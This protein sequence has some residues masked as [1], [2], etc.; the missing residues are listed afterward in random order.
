MRKYL[1]RWTAPNQGGQEAV[2]YSATGVGARDQIKQL[3]GNMPGFLMVSCQEIP[4]DNLP[5]TTSYSDTSS[6]DGGLDIQDVKDVASVSGLAAAGFLI[7]LGLITLPI[8]IGILFIIAGVLMF[9]SIYQW[10]SKA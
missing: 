7:F 3:Y 6:G 10:G 9:K 8:G 2:V 1:I 5:T 4:D